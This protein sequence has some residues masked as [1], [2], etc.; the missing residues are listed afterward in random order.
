MLLDLNK[1]VFKMLI[2]L[3]HE[4]GRV[5][6]ARRQSP[7]ENPHPT[8]GLPSL[9]PPSPGTAAHPY[10]EKKNKTVRTEVHFFINICRTKAEYFP[11]ESIE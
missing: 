4:Q 6:Q 5:P 9:C 11:P 7:P 2:Y 3:P 10:A 8:S 1:K